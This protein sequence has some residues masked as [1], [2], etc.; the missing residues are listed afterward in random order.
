MN[1]R[2][3]AEAD[4]EVVAE[5][6]RAL[7]TTFTGQSETAVEDVR[8]E[9]AQIALE[10]DAWLVELDGRIAGFAQLQLRS[11]QLLFEAYVHPDV[12]GRGVGARLAALAEAEAGARGAPTLRSAVFGS[13]SRAHALLESRGFRPVRH[14]YRMMVDLVEPPPKPR[15]PSG[16]VVSTLDYPT[17]ARAFHEA[18]EE[19]FEEEWDHAPESFE[20]WHERRTKKMAF[21]PSLWFVVRDGDEIAA[22]AVCDWKRFGMGFVGAI[23]VRKRWRRRGLG[24]G[25]L[26]HAFAEFYRRGERRVGLGV[27]ASNPTGATQLYERAGMHVAWSAVFFEKQLGV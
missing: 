18:L 22:V 5:L 26:H 14:F 25:L 1:V 6:I 13:D 3:P 20:D 16:F 10:R 19:A 7:D 9:W 23:G 8:R 11:D 4:A 24:L 21:D 17:D 27:D 12:F 15:W 2:R